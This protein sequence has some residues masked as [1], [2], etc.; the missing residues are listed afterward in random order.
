[1]HQN[2]QS[3]SNKIGPLE[4]L[5]HSKNIDIA[6]LT[7]HWI[8]RSNGS[9]L[10]VHGYW[11][12]GLFCRSDRLR[13]GVCV[14]V[15]KS[16]PFTVVEK[17]S[18]SHL[19][20]E[21]DFESVCIH[22]KE[23]NITIVTVYRSPQGDF[24]AFLNSL[25][26]LLGIL[27]RPGLKIIV[28][29]D[30]N[31]FFDR[32]WDRQF[33]MVSDVLS[34]FSIRALFSSVT[35]PSVFGGSCIDN[36]LTNIENQNLLA[37]AVSSCLSDHEA[38]M[39][40]VVL[41]QSKSSG[42]GNLVSFRNFSEKNISFF[43]DLLLSVNWDDVFTS[44]DIDKQFSVFLYK[45]SSSF[46]V[47]FPLIT[48]SSSN[49][50]SKPTWLTE[51]V[52]WTRERLKDLY[53]IQRDFPSDH[54]RSL[55]KD[56][57]K[58]YQKLISS[59]KS[60]HAAD[61]LKN[62]KNV[63]KTV[64]QIVS[65]NTGKDHAS[66]KHIQELLDGGV[67][68]NDP[69]QIA[70]IFNK[71]FTSPSLNQFNT[72]I[73]KHCFSNSSK[74]TDCPK[75]FFIAPA[76]SLEMYKTISS[77]KPS[78]SSDIFEMS[79]SVIRQ[80][81]LPLCVPL[82]QLFNNSVLQG[83]VP[84]DMK[85]SKVIP[86]FK[87]GSRSSPQQYRPISILPTISKVF[88]RLIHVRLTD[89]L[90]KNSVLSDTQFG[91][92]PSKCTTDAISQFSKHVFSQLNNHNYV[93]GIFCDLSRAFDTVNHL[94]L[95]N[96]LEH[97][98]IRGSPLEWFRSYLCSRYQRVQVTNSLGTAHSEFLE[99][100]RGVPQGSILG[101][102]LFV[103][104]MN[105]LYSC[106]PEARVIQYADDTSLVVHAK[107][108][109][110]LGIQLNSVFKKI[111]SWFV[112]NGLYLNVEKTS[113]LHFRTQN[114]KINFGVSL[115]EV[116]IIEANSVCFLGVHMDVRFSWKQHIDNLCSKLNCILFSLRCLKN[117]LDSDTLKIVYHGYFSSVMSY[118]V[119]SWGTAS[120]FHVQRVFKLQKRA[121]RLMFGLGGRESCREVFLRERILTL[122][123]VFIYSVSIFTFKHIQDFSTPS[124]LYPT[125]N[126]NNLVLPQH[127]TNMFRKSIDYLGPVI[128]NRLPDY[129]K[130]SPSLQSI[131]N[132]LKD[133][134]IENTFYSVTEFLNPTQP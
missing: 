99:V 43:N 12:A 126:K 46:N 11:V 71:A 87:K 106:V 28:C 13:G 32:Q 20:A 72:G 50:H 23:L 7:E 111:N 63:S 115:D 68:A 113:I 78:S 26:E 85:L 116:D 131:K 67:I 61:R 112:S 48:K 56:S 79:P 94:T 9:A 92:V 117:V 17:Q 83:K 70:G 24:S 6:C 51:E 80:V 19:N 73:G 33:L 81:A 74:V 121:I 65:D 109:I 53:I 22:I 124:H 128:Y 76:D 62:S 114:G 82:T 42:K 96:K 40:S 59:L 127:Q 4:A 2:I 1:M 90:L 52:V 102:L 84:S 86:I 69:Q 134:L 44:E 16:F 21:L 66:Q 39:V 45:L 107:S 120:T 47:A 130:A 118:G 55:Y 34:S 89:F 93:S 91:F 101:P 98:G 15:N 75:S 119:M 88:E 10:S 38:Q 123:S 8:P 49:K 30:F 77:L 133:F 41:Q 132:R 125:R 122:P 35:R 29:G 25:E 27:V 103:L 60:S 5:L 64:W 36:I 104:Y 31:I 18:I 105:D 57:K 110:S 108:P 14:L 100:S 97:Y 58:K 95:L 3:I 129:I 54:H 37:E